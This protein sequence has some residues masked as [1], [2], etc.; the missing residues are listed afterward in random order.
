MLINN[1]EL[2]GPVHD[3]A[4]ELD[5]LVRVQQQQESLAR[6]QLSSGMLLF[7]AIRSPTQQRLGAEVLELRESLIVCGH[8]KTPCLCARTVPGKGRKLMIVAVI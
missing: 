4:V 1:A 8:S 5:E 2:C 7:D 6:G 3:E